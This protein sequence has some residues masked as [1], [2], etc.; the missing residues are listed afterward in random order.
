MAVSP[1]NRS[2]GGIVLKLMKGHYA[3]ER[4]ERA[5]IFETLACGTRTKRATKAPIA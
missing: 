1:R 2:V 5:W 4:I 3:L